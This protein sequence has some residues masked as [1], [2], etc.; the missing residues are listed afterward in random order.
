MNNGELHIG[1]STD[2]FRE[3]QF[4]GL[5]IMAATTSDEQDFERRGLRV[6]E[7]CGREESECEEGLHGMVSLY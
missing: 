5:V 3:D 7:N 6:Q 1:A 2:A 4:L